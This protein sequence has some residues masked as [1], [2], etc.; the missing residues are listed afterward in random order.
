MTKCLTFKSCNSEVFYIIK[1]LKKNLREKLNRLGYIF[2]NFQPF[3]NISFAK[4]DRNV[5]GSENY[6]ITCT[7]L[8]MTKLKLYISILFQGHSLLQKNK[9]FHFQKCISKAAA[10]PFPMTD[11][12]K[13]IWKFCLDSVWTLPNSSCSFS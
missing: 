10:T 5:A 7:I 3:N 6:K 2:Y 1:R 9:C 4:L 13:C 11:L 8:K 12:L